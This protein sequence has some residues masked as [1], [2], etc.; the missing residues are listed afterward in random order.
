MS[1][2][3]ENPDIIS[4]VLYEWVRLKRSPYKVAKAVGISTRDVLVIVDEHGHKTSEIIERHDGWGRP[5]IREFLVGRKVATEL[6]DNTIPAIEAA[7]AAYEAG[8]VEMAIGRDGRWLLLYAFP[9][10]VTCPR[11][12]YFKPE[13]SL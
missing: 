11:P 7:R 10:K 2:N 6:W 9:R 8:T 5:E 13:L 1:L 4:D 3:T 12:A